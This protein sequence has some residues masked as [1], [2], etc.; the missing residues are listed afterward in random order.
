MPKKKESPT[1]K[2]L[3]KIAELT[4]DL[5][6]SQAD[7]INL[8]RRSEEE[9]I[10]V[11]RVVK[12]DVVTELLPVLDNIERAIGHVPEELKDNEWAQGV[13]KVAE[14]L[15]S[16]L[17]ELGVTKIATIGEE[18]DPH[19][20]EAVHAEGEGD[21]E[22]ISEELQAGYIIGDEVVRHAMVKVKRK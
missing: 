15:T 5:Q 6:R 10:T 11:S 16:K 22:I 2:M 20:H 21:K 17:A 18:F 8:K 4:E 9:R 1:E 19:L 3:D 7:F 14:Q 13:S 12:Q